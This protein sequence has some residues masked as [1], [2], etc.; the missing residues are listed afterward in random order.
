[1]Q[2]IWGRVQERFK[3][4]YIRKLLLLNKNLGHDNLKM[5]F[6]KEPSL[7]SRKNFRKGEGLRVEEQ[8]LTQLPVGYDM[9]GISERISCSKRQ[10]S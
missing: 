6:L 9:R 8:T 5:H 3:R 10:R 1:M 2:R 7:D 4:I